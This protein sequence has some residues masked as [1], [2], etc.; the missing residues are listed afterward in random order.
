MRKFFSEE[1][2][3]NLN[4]INNEMS[5]NHM[6]NISSIISAEQIE[7]TIHRLLNDKVFE[8]E[9]YQQ[10]LHQECNIKK[11]SKVYHSSSAKEKKKELLLVK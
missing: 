2:Q 7:Q 3:A 4:N 1:K 8:S 5:V 10:V 6:L 9:S 11:L